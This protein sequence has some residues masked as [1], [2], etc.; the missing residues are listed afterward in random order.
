MGSYNHHS[1]GKYLDTNYNPT[2]L[3]L[4]HWLLS[5]WPPDK[6]SVRTPQYCSHPSNLGYYRHRLH[7]LK[8]RYRRNAPDK[9]SFVPLRQRHPKWVLY[10]PDLPPTSVRVLSYRHPCQHPHHL[11]LSHNNPALPDAQ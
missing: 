9:A 3:S 10:H 11:H 2:A 6:S 5:H 1:Y 4:P 7:S 8:L